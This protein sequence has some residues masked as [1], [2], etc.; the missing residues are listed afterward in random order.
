MFQLFDA[1]FLIAAGTDFSKGLPFYYYRK[2]HAEECALQK[3]Q[4]S[5]D[6]I[7]RIRKMFRP[8]ESMRCQSIQLYLFLKRIQ[9]LLLQ[10]S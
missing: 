6:M 7:Q 3:Q 2:R 10:N 4:I 1:K 8:S 9:I 5:F